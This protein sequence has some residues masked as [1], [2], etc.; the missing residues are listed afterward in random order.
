MFVFSLTLLEP[1]LDQWEGEI[2]VSTIVQF[3]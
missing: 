3:T 2:N 1:S